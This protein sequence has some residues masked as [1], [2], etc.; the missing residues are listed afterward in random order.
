MLINLGYV[1][2]ETTLPYKSYEKVIDK[3]RLVAFPIDL[4]VDTTFKNRVWM[5]IAL[6]QDETMKIDLSNGDIWPICQIDRKFKTDNQNFI[7]F[8]ALFGPDD[9]IK[10]SLVTID[11]SGSYIDSIEVGAEI[12]C[13][14]WDYY[15]PLK[16]E[17]TEDMTIKTYQL[18][19]TSSTPILYS[20]EI[21]ETLQ[22]QRIDRIYSLDSNGKFTEIET[23]YYE[24]QNYSKD[25]FLNKG[26][27]IASGNEIPIDE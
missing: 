19:P 26:Y 24:P 6:T 12:V 1:K 10:Y 14:G 15:N 16:W 21:P 22:A 11:K 17:I 27:D 13:K 9:Y 25:K 20:N 3:G 23:K 4:I 7:L 2:T 5:D 18:K 8:S